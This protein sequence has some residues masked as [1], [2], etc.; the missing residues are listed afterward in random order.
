MAFSSGMSTLSEIEAALSELT[1]DDL[2][3]VEEML[4]RLRRRASTEESVAELE[5]RNGI[6][7]LPERSGGVV[8]IEF[9]RR[10]CAEEG[11]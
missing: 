1:P 11:V 10:L 3:R 4:Q 6:D 5:R 8:T 9:V 7:P 2:R